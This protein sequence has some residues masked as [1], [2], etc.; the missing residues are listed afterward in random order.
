MNGRPAIGR[1]LFYTRD[2]QGHSEFAPPQYV[3]W[4]QREAKRL[5]VEFAGV[6]ATITA[7]IEH[8]LSIQG[9]LY[10]DY[11]ISGNQM[12]RPGLD[13]LRRR[14]IEDLGVTHL[15][16]PRRDRIARP[17]NPLDALSIE[18]E[19]RS[20]GLT[21]VL[22]DQILEPLPRGKRVGLADLLTGV[23]DYDSSGK[24]RRE[25]AEKLIHAKIKL[26]ERG[27]SIGGE[28]VYGFRR[29]LVAPDGSRKRE[30]E[31]GEIVKMT[32]HHVIWLP[33]AEH[34]MEVV[35]RILDLIETTPATQVARILND[36]G[37]ASPKAGRIRRVGGVAVPNAGLWMQNTVK[38][39]ATHPLL[40]ACWEYGR[41]AMGDQLRFTPSGP[42]TLTEGD[43]RPDGRPK[44]VMNPIEGIIRTPAAFDPVIA[45]ER[46]DSIQ[47]ILDD[48][49]RHLKGKARTR[50][51]SPNPMGGRI[52]DLNCGWLMY[53]HARRDQW[54]YQCGLY[55]NSQ[56]KCC[57]HNVVGGETVT[58]FILGCVRQRVLAPTVLAKLE[59]RLRELAASESGDGADRQRVEADRSKL[60]ALEKKIAT[61][62]R[63]MALAETAEERAATAGVF[64]EFQREAAHLRTQIQSHRPTGSERSPE[65]EVEKAMAGL[66]RLV[67]LAKLEGDQAAVGE[68]FRQLD[69]RLYLRFH[70]TKRGRQTINK[71]NGG[72]VTFGPTPPPLPLYKGPTDRAIIRQ[73]LATGEPVSSLANN[74]KPR[75]FSSDPEAKWSAHVQRGTTKV[76]GPSRCLLFCHVGGDRVR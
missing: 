25:L 35:R 36:E 73:K 75:T 41:R 27:F 48:R 63:N 18:F 44:T 58:S 72:V 31:E 51:D 39:I 2:S 19:L 52:Y 20:A 46:L 7:M 23:I 50:R 38:N 76:S 57:T 56:A 53:R 54:G 60:A 45:K 14:A 28:P 33:T 15:F 67:D 49:G 29:W 8:N 4:A 17:D 26:A 22:M 11:G 1:G 66:N 37:I 74:A 68:L 40:I 65:R 34:E 32:G 3:A 55:Q 47:Q 9:D 5:G 71:V 10:L 42:R 59:A 6:P 64:G 69:V 16:I 13:T 62:G 21:L 24:F 61:V 43:Y 30:L 70:A 12:S